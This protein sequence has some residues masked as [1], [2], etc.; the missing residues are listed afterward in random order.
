MLLVMLQVSVW[1]LICVMPVRV[2]EAPGDWCET[3]VCLSR[4]MAS[5]CV[6]KAP[7][8]LTSRTTLRVS[9]CCVTVKSNETVWQI[10]RQEGRAGSAP[11]CVINGEKTPWAE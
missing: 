8:F 10:V 2:S 5:Q 4:L 9:C 6:H 3:A 7:L 11:H 1:R